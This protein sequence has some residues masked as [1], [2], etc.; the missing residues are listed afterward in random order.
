MED[1]IEN[2]SLPSLELGEL[3]SS[4]PIIEDIP[5]RTVIVNPSTVLKE[6]ERLYFKQQEII[7]ENNHSNLNRINNNK[8]LPFS[9]QHLASL[10]SN[11]ELNLVEFFINEFVEFQLRNKAVLQQHRLNELLMCYLQAR[12]HLIVNS[13]ELEILKKLCKETQKQVWCLDKAD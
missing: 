10:C 9:E 1:Y 2:P 3:A 13:L 8:L 6:T 5:T 4:A 11:K 7:T 12:N